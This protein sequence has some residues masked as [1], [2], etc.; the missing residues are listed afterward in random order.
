MKRK[1]RIGFVLGS[2]AVRHP[3]AASLSR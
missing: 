1:R 2:G 3:H